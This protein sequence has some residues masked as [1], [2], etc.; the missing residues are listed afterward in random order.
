M[1][2]IL[3]YPELWLALLAIL[4]LVAG[5]SLL[6]GGN[7]K[8]KKRLEKILARSGSKR[9]IASPA[10]SLRKV[11]PSSDTALGKM[12]SSYASIEK[13]KARFEQAGMQITPAR[14]LRT[15]LLIT[16]GTALALWLLLGAS[17]LLA[18]LA[19]F[20]AGVGIPHFLVS[21][22]IKKRKLKFLK[23]FPEGIDLI[24]RGLR[25]GLPVAESFTVV[26]REI[27]E[28]VSGVF[29][30]ISQQTALG[31]PMEQALS[32]TAEKLDMTEFNFFVTTIILQRETGGN[33]GEV[34]SN[35]AEVLRD[36]QVMKL[37][38]T[39]L[40]SEARASA[41]IVGAL[42]F[43]VF[44]VLNLISPEYLDPLYNDY[45]GNMAIGIAL[46]MMT[47]GGFI[48]KRMTQFEI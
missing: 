5:P 6:K 9:S 44:G 21:R 18:A 16:V 40:S 30:T 31:L 13:L 42:P 37:K 35:L 46:G 33:L 22:K 25:A 7:A 38:I 47:F 11:D 27:P 14:F 39:A 3:A 17:P 12:L 41:Y 36:R 24:V 26:S 45:R 2:E 29:A 43:F 20:I 15:V 28:P 48:M 10:A 32:A 19:G 1:A 23:L 8:R 34:L 4:A